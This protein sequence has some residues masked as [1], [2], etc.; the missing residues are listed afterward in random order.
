MTA[1]NILWICTDQQRSDSL[2][3]Y[4]STEV[5]S[6]NIDSIAASGVRFNRHITPMQIC[7]PSRATMITGKYPRNH[8][9]ITNGMALPESVPTL[10]K[11]LVENGYQTHAV[12]KQHLQPILAASE[13]NMPD[14]RAFWKKPES[15]QWNGP[16]YGY[17]TIDLLIGESDT[18]QIAGHYASWL[19]EHYPQYVE[20]LKPKHAQQT[21]PEDLDE[22]WRSAMPVE[23]HY[24]TWITDC[25]VNFLANKRRTD[26][27]FCL[28]VSF[29]DP[30]HPFDPPVEYAD[31]YSA[32]DMTLPE[33]TESDLKGRPPYCD[34]LFPK[35][36]GFRKLYWRADKGAEA[37]SSITTED[38]SDE[39]LRLAIAYTHAQVE[40][41]DDGVGRMLQ[42]LEAFGLDE[43][44][45]VIFTSD[46]G[47]YLGN[48]GLLHK[49]PASYRQLTELSL[50]IKGPGFESGKQV[51][52]LT[53]HIDLMPTLLDAAQ[54]KNSP[55]VDGISLVP[56]LT[57]A[58]ERVR[59]YTFGEY[60]PTVRKELYN[61]TIYYD[62]WRMT[63]YPGMTE[64]GELFNLEHDPL[65][66]ENLY[67]E[68]DR[69]S[70]REKLTQ[71]LHTEFPSQPT[72]ENKT[73]AKW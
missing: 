24:N 70:I 23:C 46:H 15:A 26:K 31:R 30:H 14:S 64:W 53:S 51:N 2:G 57:G 43:N 6:P 12:G 22:I 69:K 25:S 37:G 9:L 36:Q 7:S 39:S 11:T 44:T 32:D 21:P 5:R 4:G 56:L 35:G 68:V 17:E 67:F 47:E 59:D 72:V 3:C 8:Q 65:E 41:I 66:L 63:L 73:L 34:D 52:S 61:Q 42:Q 28:F 18:A 71:L 48:H 33:V 1:P 54:V 13:L 38:I 20:Y 10:T 45:I 62:Q 58:D 29:P 60:H 16:Y 19:K 49:G 27:P 40:M 50:L 55:A